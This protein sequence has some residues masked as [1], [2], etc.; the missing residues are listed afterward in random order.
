MR[1][2]SNMTC[3]V[4]AIH[5]LDAEKGKVNYMEAAEPVA[6][7]C[8]TTEEMFQ[9]HTT[10]TQHIPPEKEQPSESQLREEFEQNYLEVDELIGTPGEMTEEM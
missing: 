9:G 4:T 10:D 2:F 6:S 8:V 1:Y 7:P 5:L 3:Y